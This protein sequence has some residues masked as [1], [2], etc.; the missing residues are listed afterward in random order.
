MSNANMNQI[1]QYD[2]EHADALRGIWFLGDIHAEY[3]HLA[4][5]LLHS[6]RAPNWLVFLGGY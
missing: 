5:T 6:Q 1:D 3:K 4:S 2:Q